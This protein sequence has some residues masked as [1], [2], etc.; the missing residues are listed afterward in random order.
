MFYSRI[1]KSY[2][3]CLLLTLLLL[4]SSLAAAQKTG[5]KKTR[6]A[7]AAPTGA[8]KTETTEQTTSTPPT[9]PV[10]TPTEPVRPVK[11]SSV[12]RIGIV[13]PK[14]ALSGV[15]EATAADAVQ[16]TFYEL[17]KSKF[18]EVIAIEA[19]LPIQVTPEAEEKNIGYILYSTLSQKKGKSDGGLFGKITGRVANTVSSRIPYG[20]GIG[21]EIAVAT[22]SEA[23]RTVSTLADSIKAKDELTLE[24]KLVRV[25]DSK[26]VISN[27]AKAQAKENGEDIITGLIEAAANEVLTSIGSAGGSVRAES[28]A[29]SVAPPAAAPKPAAPTSNALVPFIKVM[30]ESFAPDYVGQTIR[31]KVRFVASGQTQNWVFGSIPGS[32][33]TGKMAFRVFDEATDSSEATMGSVLPHIFIDKQNADLVFDL[34][35]G[36]SLILTGSPVVGSTSVGSGGKYT[37]I[38]FVA[39]SIE[40]AK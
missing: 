19:R 7:T 35:K 28:S 17:M 36:D 13:S 24:Y 32:A 21:G 18:V 39:T 11:S 4:G 26:A 16:N 33:M 20:R 40:R 25:A 38:I 12:Q 23:L 8:K 3:L 31:T 10:R 27:S 1:E 22:A 14:A 37:Q 6:P 5:G 34:K 9:E 30:N 2:S 15:A 29:A